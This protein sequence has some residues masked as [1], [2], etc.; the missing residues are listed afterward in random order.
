MQKYHRVLLALAVVSLAACSTTE[1]KTE[2][3]TNPITPSLYNN[4]NHAQTRSIGNTSGS[5][6]TA[7]NKGKMGMPNERIV[8]FEFDKSEMRSEDR[9]VIENNAKYLTGSTNT[10]VRLEGHADERGSR[11]YNRALSERRADSV[12]RSLNML[13]VSEQQMSTLSYGEE[14]PIDMGHD[15]TAWQQ[16]RRVEIVYP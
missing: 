15:E 9:A 13:G 3:N 4:A 14:H 6:A 8:R 12:K 10:S 16:N 5:D 7:L 2:T 1:E 11:E